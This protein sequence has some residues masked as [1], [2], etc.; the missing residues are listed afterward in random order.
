MECSAKSVF[1]PVASTNPC[2]QDN[3]SSTSSRVNNLLAVMVCDGTFRP[4]LAIWP[5]HY[6]IKFVKVSMA[7]TQKQSAESGPQPG[8][9]VYL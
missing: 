6:T 4:S 9:A 1:S 3:Y 7:S 5:I 2:M 8:Q